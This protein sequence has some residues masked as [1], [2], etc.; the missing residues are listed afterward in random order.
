MAEV[1]T[2]DLSVQIAGLNHKLRIVDGGWLPSTEWL[3][4]KLA[5]LDLLA[6]MKA[7]IEDVHK[8]VVKNP[9][10][11][12]WEAA[13]FDGI[14][15][16]IEKLYE[17]EGLGTALKYWLSNGAGA[18]A[19]VLVGGIG[20]YLTG[21]FVSLR[22]D[23]QELISRLPGGT[24]GM[25]RGYDEHGNVTRQTRDDIER[26]ERRVANGGTSLA[27]LPGSAA[28]AQIGPLRD[29]LENLNKEVLKFNNRAPA[30]LQSFRKLPTE[31]KAEK[32]AKG[33]ERIATAI[34]GVDHTRMQP[35]AEGVNK[36]N[37]AMRNADP[38]KVEKVARATDKLKTAMLGFNPAKIPKA[39]DIRGTDTAMTN[40]AAATGTL[41]TKFNEL[42]LT[43]Q[44][45]DQQLGA[46]G[47]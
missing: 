22:R 40:L 38:K 47:G 34:A 20:V 24:P 37:N 3:K 6:D 29:Q 42:R 43:V 5:P 12:Y 16:G 14:A 23:M 28:T 10:S 19:A 4:V 15:A 44:S 8:E 21:K 31:A 35:V 26:R 27:D 2:E 11:E 9:V 30:F 1:T 41:R 45:L 36:I 7:K 32:A 13:G 18:F 17:G 25:I 33:V 46:T 39:A